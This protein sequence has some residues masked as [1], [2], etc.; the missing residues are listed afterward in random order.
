MSYF[1]TVSI[2]PNESIK[3]TV[4][5]SIPTVYAIT[6]LAW[7]SPCQTAPTNVCWWCAMKFSR[8]ASTEVKASASLTFLTAD[9]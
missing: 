1:S 8:A 6:L 2:G 4:D 9:C 3:G 7:I 5:F